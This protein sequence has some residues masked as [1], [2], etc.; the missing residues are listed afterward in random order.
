VEFSDSKYFIIP[1]QKLPSK[2]SSTSSKL[3][4]ISCGMPLALRITMAA[5]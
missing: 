5:L 1:W 2:M 3:L 4:F